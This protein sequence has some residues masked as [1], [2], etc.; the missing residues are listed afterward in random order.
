[1][2]NRVARPLPTRTGS[3]S[4]VGGRRSNEDSH[5]EHDFGR[6]DRNPW[7]LQ[8]MVAVADGMGGAAAGEVASGIAA[9]WM[10]EIFTSE[11][12]AKAAPT[13]N[14][15]AIDLDRSIEQA[16]ATANW[17]V[18]ERAS[19]EERYR[20]MGST[21]TLAV[22]RDNVFHIGHVGD[23]RA[24]LIRDGRITQ[25]TNDHSPAAALVQSGQM[26]EEQARRSPF[27]G[28]VSRAL[29]LQP[30]VQVDTR[31]LPARSGDILLLCSDGLSEYVSPQEIL[32]LCLL[33]RGPQEACD[34]LVGRALTR[35]TTDNVTAAALEVLSPAGRRAFARPRP[36]LRRLVAVAGIAVALIALGIW[37]QLLRTKLDLFPDFLQRIRAR[38]PGPGT[39]PPVPPATQPPTT[40]LP[41]PEVAVSV[42]WD[43]TGPR[44]T[45]T[46][47]PGSGSA[48][49]SLKLADDE[50]LPPGRRPEQ[51]GPA[52]VC[53]VPTSGKTGG[54]LRFERVAATGPSLQLAVPRQDSARLQPNAQYKLHWKGEADTEETYLFTLEVVAGTAPEQEGSPATRLKVEE[55]TEPGISPPR[56][57]SRESYPRPLP[58][59]EEKHI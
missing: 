54:A 30:T 12:K 58:T 4:H 22:L 29:G 21:L 44:T 40:A 42:L 28:Q 31:Q 16:L 13:T 25:L 15:G 27:Y 3:R 59:G 14:G 17:V 37:F 46:I 43:I 53:A 50:A 2:V 24:Y 5:C 9:D 18:H 48:G 38:V 34:R 49:V 36:R 57:E 41:A 45:L 8:A 39:A 52:V 35:G 6:R 32:H 10:D 55:F 19:A 26:S 1:M 7:R 33:T 20:G 51:Q 47:A 56:G 11:A 23:S